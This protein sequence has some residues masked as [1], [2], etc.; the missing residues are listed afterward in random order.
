[1]KTVVTGAAG[2]IGSNLIR[3][4]VNEGRN[5]TAVD[6]MSRGSSKNLSGLAIETLTVDLTCYE[7]TI[8]ALDEADQ[9]YHLAA[10]VGSI[11]YLHAGKRAELDAL[12]SN[13]E[14]DR[15]VFRACLENGV[16]KVIYA[17]SVA[18]YPIHLQQT[19]NAIFSE[20]DLNPINPDGGY[21]WAKLL[22]EIQ[23][24]LMDG[25]KSSIAR[26]FETYGEYSDF[27]ETAHVV[28]ALIRKA[29]NYPREDFVVWGDGNQTRNLMYIADCVEALV[30]MEE[31]ADYPPVIMNIGNPRTVTIRELAETIVK[32]S[33]K[34]IPIKFDTSKPVGPLSRIPDISKS[35]NLLGLEPSYSLEDGLKRT[36]EFMRER[37]S[38]TI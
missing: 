11:D 31:K 33:G 14:I 26:I 28:P 2:F 36:Y 9:V 34:E 10:R 8:R 7:Q 16:K 17:S 37:I 12:Q 38:R 5:V 23:L 21:G 6:N 22:G 30:K 24:D 25:C 18:V 15:N 3:R 35:R 13:L 29:V 27:G 1:M 32:V 19:L 4:L 20:P